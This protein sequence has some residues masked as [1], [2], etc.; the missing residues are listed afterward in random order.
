MG[1]P[2]GGG[3]GEA[4]LPCAH[5]PQRP[6]LSGDGNR[7][8]AK[9]GRAG[10]LLPGPSAAR[11]AVRAPGPPPGPRPPQRGERRGAPRR[12]PYPPAGAAARCRSSPDPPPRCRSNP[13][14]PSWQHGGPRGPRRR[15]GRRRGW[16]RGRGRARLTS[17]R[18][19]PQAGPGCRSRPR[20]LE[21]P[22][23]PLGCFSEAVF[24]RGCRPGEVCGEREKRLQCRLSRSTG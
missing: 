7:G 16:G 5:R 12:V 11:A 10:P 22:P 9:P 20:P 6:R 8:R 13:P 23:E 15:H 4:A 18:A 17:P 24:S 1:R 19:S 3:Q 14:P 21:V 2:Q